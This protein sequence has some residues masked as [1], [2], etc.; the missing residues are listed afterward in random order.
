[1]TAESQLRRVS[2]VAGGSNNKLKKDLVS[3]VA[4][5]VKR[6]LLK[7]REKP[8]SQSDGLAQV[9]FATRSLDELTK[10]D[11]HKFNSQTLKAIG[12]FQRCR[13]ELMALNR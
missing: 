5:F 6:E 10:T 4:L 3:K 11:G 13:V 2:R 7:Q 1:M 8:P 12:A 9:I